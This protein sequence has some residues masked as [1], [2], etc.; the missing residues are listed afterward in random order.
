METVEHRC[1]NCRGEVCPSCR[2]T[3]E[4]CQQSDCGIKYHFR[5]SKEGV[6]RCRS[7]WSWLCD[8]CHQPQHDYQCEQFEDAPNDWTP[9][10]RVKVVKLY[11]ENKLQMTQ[12]QRNVQSPDKLQLTQH[13]G[14][15]QSPDV[16]DTDESSG[17]PDILGE[18]EVSDIS[19]SVHY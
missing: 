14:N 11:F 3:F 8:E 15:V 5:E 17:L 6:L 16:S 4:Y 18:L 9:K 10:D 19:M 7:C 1:G 2:F 13:Q 12:R